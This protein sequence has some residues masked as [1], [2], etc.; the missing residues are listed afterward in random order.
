MKTI[1]TLR[2]DESHKERLNELAHLHKRTVSF[3]ANEMITQGLEQ[4]EQS[5]HRESTERGQNILRVLESKQTPTH[6]SSNS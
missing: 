1:L 6:C 4:Y 3:I 5:T 2:I